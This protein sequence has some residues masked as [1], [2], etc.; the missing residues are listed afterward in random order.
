MARSTM[1]EFSTL[2][3]YVFVQAI[4]MSVCVCVCD[5][6]YASSPDMKV[7]YAIPLKIRT[8]AVLRSPC[9]NQS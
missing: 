5:K 3:E 8:R 9:R 7:E 2:F 6:P 1:H 4:N